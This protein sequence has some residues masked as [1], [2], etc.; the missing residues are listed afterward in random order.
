MLDDVKCYTLSANWEMSCSKWQGGI[1]VSRQCPRWTRIICLDSLTKSPSSCLTPR[2]TLYLHE[3][4]ITS[5]ELTGFTGII[6]QLTLLAKHRASLSASFY[7][8]VR[9]Y[10]IGCSNRITV[11]SEFV[12]NFYLS[13]SNLFSLLIT[14]ISAQGY[15]NP[16]LI[17]FKTRL[18]QSPFAISD[19]SHRSC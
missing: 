19:N 13:A 8:F 15:Q 7:L 12:Q 6:L 17:S 9:H 11:D 16:S 3:A 10:C 14:N 2:N 5:K 4:F 18:L 1:T